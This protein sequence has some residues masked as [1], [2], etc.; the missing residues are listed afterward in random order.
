[1]QPKGQLWT[2]E[3]RAF[4]ESYQLLTITADL[5]SLQLRK[6]CNVNLPAARFDFFRESQRSQGPNASGQKQTARSL[7]LRARQR[8]ELRLECAVAVRTECLLRNFPVE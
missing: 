3:I 2:V 6:K 7:A 1:M 5:H 8:I 4:A